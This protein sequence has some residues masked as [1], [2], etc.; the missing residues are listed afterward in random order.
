MDPH[1]MAIKNSYTHVSIPRAHLRPDL[2]KQLAVA[3]CPPSS[4]FSE[5]QPLSVG[6]CGP[7]PT[8]LLQPIEAPDPKGAK[9]AAPF[10]DQQTWGQQGNPY[11]SAQRPAGL[12]YSGL[13]PIGRGDDIAH[14]CC[15][16]PCCSCC[17]C[18]RFCR[19]H[20]CCCVIS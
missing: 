14:H 1:E 11:G 12:T 5:T 8:R 7:E 4:S 13:P 10:Q 17:H 9:G 6:S 2:V 19:C 18:P 15:C 3:P 20:S 16:I